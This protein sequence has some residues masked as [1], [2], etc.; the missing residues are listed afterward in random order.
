MKGKTGFYLRYSGKKLYNGVCPS[1]DVLFA[2]AACAGKMGMGIILSGMGKDGAE[3]LLQMRR[4]GALT[5]GQN[6]A[7]SPVYGM[8]YEAKKAGAVII[9]C[10]PEQI[11]EQ[12]IRFSGREE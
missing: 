6:K 7:S 4:A 8:P 11:V 1:A 3:G 2:S 9:E 5:V 10:T 12:I